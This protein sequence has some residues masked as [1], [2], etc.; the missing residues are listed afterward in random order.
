MKQALTSLHFLNDDKFNAV[1]DLIEQGAYTIET[2]RGGLMDIVL[3]S[4]ILEVCNGAAVDGGLDC[5][6]RLDVVGGAVHT[7][8]GV[9]PLSSGFDTPDTVGPERCG[10]TIH[11][12][13]IPS[14]IVAPR[15]VHCL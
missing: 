8:Y 4:R 3:G 5:A 13:G 15:S 14:M 11:A 2:R 12:Q 7:A 10:T 9:Q 6:V 1:M